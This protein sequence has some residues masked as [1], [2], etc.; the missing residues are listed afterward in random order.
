M[1]RTTAQPASSA[2]HHRLERCNLSQEQR[3]TREAAYAQDIRR[4]LPTSAPDTNAWQQWNGM[5][6][7]DERGREIEARLPHVGGVLAVSDS[8]F[9]Q[10]RN[11]FVWRD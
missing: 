4:R 2:P 3:G 1:A 5:P 8:T 7:D 11:K 9:A 6:R 10:L